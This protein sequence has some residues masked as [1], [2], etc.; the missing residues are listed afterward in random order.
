MDAP[1]NKTEQSLAAIFRRSP[2]SLQAGTVQ[3]ATMGGR[4]L[5]RRFYRVSCNW[6]Y[7]GLHF[8]QPLKSSLCQH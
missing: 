3:R 7:C 6:L 2:N 4:T 5:P 1:M 8:G